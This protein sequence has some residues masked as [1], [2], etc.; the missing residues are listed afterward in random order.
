M[1]G[2]TD[3]FHII[4]TT[5]AMRRLKP[6]PVPEELVQQILEA[7]VC[8]ASGGNSQRWRF[9][10]I[11]DREIKEQVQKWYQKAFDEF[12]GPRYRSSAPPPG[13]SP[14]VIGANMTRLST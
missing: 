14:G 11:K 8:A 13:S 12:V 6:D 4:R 2:G 9:M 1:T 7:G 10:V 3:L 5:R